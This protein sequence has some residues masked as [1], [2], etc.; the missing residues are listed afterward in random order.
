MRAA[1]R[2]RRPC[3]R[4][5]MRPVPRHRLV[6]HLPRD[7]HPGVRRRGR[8]DRRQTPRHARPGG[9]RHAPRRDAL[10]DDIVGAGPQLGQRYQ[11]LPV[12]RRGVAAPACPGGAV[13]PMGTGLAGGRAAPVG[14]TSPSARTWASRCRKAR[15]DGCG[16]WP[17]SRTRCPRPRGH[18][19]GEGRGH[20]LQARG[21]IRR[22]APGPPRRAVPALPLPRPHRGRGIRTARGAGE[23]QERIRPAHRR[24]ARDGPHNRGRRGKGAALAADGAGDPPGAR[25]SGS[26]RRRR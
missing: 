22:D 11:A 2:R 20:C 7:G 8:R 4:Y 16:T 17:A 1:G 13:M 24:R 15:G 10:P 18:R 3:L 19:H 25:A 21:G 5:R 23:S 9:R 6:S 14:A 12:N 26:A